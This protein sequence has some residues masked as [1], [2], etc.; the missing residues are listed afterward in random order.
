MK[1]ILFAL[2]M[3]TALAFVSTAASA[4]LVTETFTG[5]VTGVDTFGKFGAAG[6]TLNTTF[7]SVYFFDT[8]SGNTGNSTTGFFVMGAIAESW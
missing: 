6:A 4:A 2:S 5:T 7:T 8:S 3:C 1:K